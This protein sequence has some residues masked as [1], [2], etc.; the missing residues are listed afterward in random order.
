MKYL[1]W[2]PLVL[3][4]PIGIVFG[5]YFF[6][7][8][9]TSNLQRDLSLNSGRRESSEL[10]NFSTVLS[11]CESSDT[12]LNNLLLEKQSLTEGSQAWIINQQNIQGVQL[13]KEQCKSRLQSIIDT[14]EIENVPEFAPLYSRYL[15]I[16]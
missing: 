4:L 10:I 12:L 13:S 2:L 8:H 1:L 9:V 3:T 7:R 11:Q 15:E 14:T 6:E 5:G 16:K